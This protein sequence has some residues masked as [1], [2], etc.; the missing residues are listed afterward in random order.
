MSRIA[1]ATGSAVAIAASNGFIGQARLQRHQKTHGPVPIVLPCS[2][3]TKHLGKERDC[4][5]QFL[6]L[7]LHA[8][9]VSQCR[10]GDGENGPALV[11]DQGPDGFTQEHFAPQRI[12]FFARNVREP[13]Q[14]QHA[15]GIAADLATHLL[16]GRE[17]LSGTR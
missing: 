17:I 4:T 15:H 6:L 1:G 14:V 5:D 12:P 3:M 7:V 9:D 10:D 16:A 2:R 11:F 8:E 13:N